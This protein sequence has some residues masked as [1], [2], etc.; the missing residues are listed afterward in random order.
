MQ[1][2]KDKLLKLRMIRK[3]IEN[4]KTD[5]V[6]PMPLSKS[7]IWPWNYHLDSEELIGHCVTQNAGPV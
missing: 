3:G 6:M 7:M 5:I 2:K 1:Y 4:E